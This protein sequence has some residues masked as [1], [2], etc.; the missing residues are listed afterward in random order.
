M[1]WWNRM[2]YKWASKEKIK[3]AN[4]QPAHRQFEFSIQFTNASERRWVNGKDLPNFVCYTKF[5]LCVYTL[6]NNRLMLN[7]NIDSHNIT[8]DWHTSDKHIV[9]KRY[10]E[11]QHLKLKK[12][13]HFID[14]NRVQNTARKYQHIYVSI[15]FIKSAVGRKM[16]L[17]HS[18]YETLSSKTHF[19]R[20]VIKTRKWLVLLSRISFFN[21]FKMFSLGWI[22]LSHVPSWIFFFAFCIEILNHERR[23]CI[24]FWAKM[25]G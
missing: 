18:I 23:H 4:T 13:T 16:W 17:L 2:R 20:N 24:Y 6:P 11:T 8:K 21:L 15:H 1:Y 14:S 5:G 19:F 7:N 9:F 25:L 12:K 10:T 3:R 22:F